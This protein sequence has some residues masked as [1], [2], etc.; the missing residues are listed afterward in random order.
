VQKKTERPFSYN[1]PSRILEKNK[2]RNNTIIEGLDEADPNG[3]GGLTL[4]S[5]AKGENGKGT[6]FAMV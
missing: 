2:V 6:K 3:G 1:E 5:Q 4:S